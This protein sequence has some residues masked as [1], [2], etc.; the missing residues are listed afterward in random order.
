MSIA[1]AN[2]R[3]Y[4]GAYIKCDFTCLQKDEDI[5]Q[6]MMCMKTLANS[7]LKPFQLKHHLNNARKEQASKLVERR[8]SEKR[9][10]MCQTG[11]RRCKEKFSIV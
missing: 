6:G 10:Q 1:E 5:P 2:K 9:S 11:C 4:K 8:R 7:S 3:N